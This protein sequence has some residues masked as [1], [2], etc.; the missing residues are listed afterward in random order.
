[1]KNY[2]YGWY[3]KCQSDSNTLAIIDAYHNDK[4]SIQIITDDSAM[5]FTDNLEKAMFNDEGFFID[6]SDDKN[7]V[8]GEIRFGKFTKIS[9]DIMGPFKCVPFLQ[10]RHM[11]KSMKHRIDGKIYV[12]GSEYNF[13]DFLCYIEGD[14][15]RSFPKEYLWTHTF[16]D[17]GSLML[18]V[19][20]IPFTFFHFTGIIGV[21]Y[22]KN[23]EYRIA[24]Y[25][26]A[27]V[28]KLCDNSVEISQGKYRLTAKLIKKNSHPLNAPVSGEMIRTIHESA[29]CVASYSFYID[30][31]KIFDFETDKASFEY[32]YK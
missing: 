9:Y 14:K 23:K 32:E 13:D 11:V 12:N 5:C 26:G 8:K 27:K 17:E 21:I 20:D 30:N 7:V 6:L 4:R 24:T 10:C 22:Y 19:A 2:F 1:M 29:S 16:F 31:K 3:Y 15:G 28:S 25:L 18:S